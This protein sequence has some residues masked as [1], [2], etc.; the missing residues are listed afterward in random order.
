M[1]P[2]NNITINLK[3][4]HTPEGGYDPW[5]RYVTRPTSKLELLSLTTIGLTAGRALTLLFW[6][7]PASWHWWAL[8]FVGT[9]LYG[10]FGSKPICTCISVGVF[11]SILLGTL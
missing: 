10:L 2:D 5:Q 11:I 8:L 9:F 1:K 6:L 7:I 3:D 4:H